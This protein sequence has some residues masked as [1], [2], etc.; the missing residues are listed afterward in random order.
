M[1][2]YRFTAKVTVLSVVVVLMTGAAMAQTK[3]SI[4]SIDA[5]RTEVLDYLVRTSGKETVLGIE[6]KNMSR[7]ASDTA[8][9]AEL[10]GKSPAFWG[11]DFGFGHRAVDNRQSMTEE[12]K[13]QWQQGAMV[14]LMYHTCV[15]T[16]DEFCD[17]DD[18][19]GKHPVHLTDAQW[20]ELMTPDTGLNKAWF[21][22]LDT[23]AAYFQQLQDAGVITLF[24]PF[25]E[26]NQCVFWW[27]CHKG[28][29]GTAR[30]YEITH[31][32][33]TKTK[34]LHNI[35]WVWNVQDFK[36]LSTDVDTYRPSSSAFDMAS[37]DVYEKE[38]YTAEKYDLLRRAA[39]GK[40]IA[41]GECKYY[42]TVETL[43]SQTKW[44]YAM[45]WPDF[46]EDNRAT[47]PALFA[48]PEVITL[49]KMPG[50]R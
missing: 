17:W 12:A 30:L 1:T 32:Y 41:I 27:S 19:G 8:R 34:G 38:G 2:I 10:A 9:V 3:P 42:P 44:V 22:R 39:G 21:G 46:I 36:T 15:P 23:L 40:P 16:R 18:I 35:I 11:A 5:K 14:S 29:N 26:M 45:L 6:N 37:L 43:R 50:W 31:D 28:P 49:E 48:A 47:A 25:H 24:R 13:R 7:P 20:A 33:L 4:S